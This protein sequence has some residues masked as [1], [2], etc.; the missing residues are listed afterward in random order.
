MENLFYYLIFGEIHQEL[1]FKM[2]AETFG[3]LI[4]RTRKE[5]SMAL[6]ELAANIDLDQSLLSKI[7]RNQL[8][9]PER[10][11]FKLSRA[12]EL[13]YA[14]LQKR[15]LSDRLYQELKNT[16]Y[17][18]EAVELVLQRLQRE[19]KGTGFGLKRERLL[20]RIREFFENQPIEKAWIF[21]SFARGEE[22]YDSDL[23]I[24][25]RFVEPNDLD[26]FD[27]VGIRQSLE[28]ITGRQI[29][30][31]EEGQELES[32]KPV[33][34]QEKKVIY[35]RQAVRAGKVETYNRSDR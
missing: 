14:D 19:K 4:R 23:D 21:G 16:D 7:E 5:K 22:S 10:V 15:Y 26:L 28:D 27:Y 20:D 1:F 33:I 24:L 32:I 34:E 2:N 25:V 29:D 35:E 17:S 11:I 3:E 18:L 12:L 9:A 31:V 6:R 30:L 8:T 13:D